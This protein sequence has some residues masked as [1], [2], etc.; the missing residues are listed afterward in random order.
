MRKS[1]FKGRKRL[2]I[3][4]L[5]LFGIGMYFI[6][7]IDSLRFYNIKKSI[8]SLSGKVELIDFENIVKLVSPDNMLQAKLEI[9]N[10]HPY[11]TLEGFPRELL[12]RQN[13]RILK[14]N[15]LHPSYCL[16]VFSMG[17][18]SDYFMEHYRNG[19]LDKKSIEILEKTYLFVN[20]EILNPFTL[21]V[22][23]TADHVISE[24]IQFISLFSAYISH[25]Y[26]YKKELLKA[27]YKD[28]NI[29]L[30]F[31]MDKKSFTWQTNHGIMQLRSLA[32]I[33]GVVK[34]RNLQE[35]IIKEVDLRLSDI[36]PYHIGPDGAIYEA[37]SGYWIYIYSQFKKIT[38]I[39]AIAHLKSVH[40]LNEEL[41]KS[42]QFISTVASNDGFLQGL[43]DSYSIFINEIFDKSEV[44]EN[45]FFRFTNKLAGANWSAENENFNVL[46]VS[47]DSPPNV[48]KLPDDLA[49]YFY[50]GYPVFSNT[51]TYSY[52]ASK[53]RQYFRSEES[54]ST[55][56]L[57]HNRYAEPAGSYLAEGNYRTSDS[58]IIFTGEK[59][60]TDGK[61]IN[62]VLTINPF[63]EISIL[64]RTS[65]S[66]TLLT[67]YNLNPGIKI[68]DADDNQIVL[69]TPDSTKILLISNRR[70]LITNGMISE[71]KE[72]LTSIKRLAI[73]GN[74]ILIRIKFPELQL[75]DRM[76]NVNAT[77]DDGN[78]LN[79]S[80]YLSSKYRNPRYIENVRKL[81]IYRL[82]F[83]I[84]A[85][86]GFIIIMEVLI[87]NLKNR[88]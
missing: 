9:I 15:I 18:A 41:Q 23:T 69:Q 22:V 70:I 60:Y 50:A 82:T 77:P 4:T 51:G 28:F 83:F 21:N 87:L 27:L 33:A 64:D 36:I 67:Y 32:Q 1:I 39:K 40:K 11:L 37:A 85:F 19:T 25:Y 38:E 81:V 44:P 53:E 74:P 73:T 31:L 8:F 55:V 88:Q 48:H 65:N 43:G 2:I 59:R 42:R 54:Q 57:L 79:Y 13:S 26:P 62:R 72:E 71:K 52:D 16:S 29:C 76:I 14:R 78:R 17:Y 10:D 45:R 3:Y 12:E 68:K 5:I 63:K 75:A 84:L 56:N 47:L 49:V 80:T 58:T 20:S 86:L 6:T 66:D 7:L 30:G 35:R 34:N 61:S 46:F 24:R